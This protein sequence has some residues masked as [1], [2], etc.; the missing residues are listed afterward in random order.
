MRG[1]FETSADRYGWF[2]EPATE[3]LDFREDSNT[4]ASRSRSR[5]SKSQGPKR[6]GPRCFAR[7]ARGADDL[8]W[9]AQQG[10]WLAAVTSKL[11]LTLSRLRK[12]SATENRIS[13]LHRRGKTA[14]SG[15]STPSV[16]LAA[17]HGL[18]RRCGS[19]PGLDRISA[20]DAN[21]GPRQ[22][23]P[24]TT[25]HRCSKKGR[26][27]AVSAC[28]VTA[29]PCRLRWRSSRNAAG[30]KTT[31]VKMRK[32]WCVAT[33]AASKPSARA[34]RLISARPPGE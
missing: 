17:N 10:P 2:G 30:A 1:R 16:A 18:G 33:K 14:S 27:R 7:T 20:S 6:Y 3:S 21:R 15:R 25:R 9:A 26:F 29:Y 31:M 13:T 8:R 22:I 28:F 23:C 24:E 19:L 12:S 4:R 5:F 32:I 34:M 11:A